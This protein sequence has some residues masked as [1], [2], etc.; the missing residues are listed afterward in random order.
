MEYKVVRRNG[1][2]SI[3]VDDKSYFAYKPE[4]IKG[5]VYNTNI[6]SKKKK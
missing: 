5:K 3:V 2:A 6:K 1:V 4:P